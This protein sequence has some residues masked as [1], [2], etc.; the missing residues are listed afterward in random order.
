MSINGTSSSAE[1]FTY[2]PSSSSNDGAR[3]ALAPV[4]PTEYT[5]FGDAP[6]S[7]QTTFAESGARHGMSDLKLGSVIDGETD[8]SPYPLSD[9]SSDGI[10]DD[11]GIQFLSLFR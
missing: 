2:G 8:G 4:E 1:F 3:C 10:D 6:D 5:D 9:D 11:D 7:Y